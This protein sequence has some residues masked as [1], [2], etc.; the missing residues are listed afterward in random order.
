MIRHEYSRIAET[1][2]EDRLE[3]GLGVFV[4]SKP[5]FRKSYAFFATRY[6]GM[7]TRFQLDGQWLDTP[8]GIAHYLEHKMFD[9]PDGG[10]ALSLCYFANSALE[11]C[12]LHTGID[13]KHA[14]ILDQRAVGK[15]AKRQRLANI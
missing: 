4:F 3:N 6:G 9:M 10:N 2:Y 8:M 1:M 12:K 7:D 5:E 14:F 15:I 11:I 13:M